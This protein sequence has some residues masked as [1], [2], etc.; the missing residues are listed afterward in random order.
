MLKHFPP[1]VF[2]LKGDAGVE[3]NYEG[4]AP[5][6]EALMPW[7][8]VKALQY[9]ASSFG[10]SLTVTLNEKGMLGAK[11]TKIKL[12][13]LGKQR[14]AFNDTAGHYWRRYQIM[15]SQQ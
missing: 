2:K 1:V 15:R 9:N 3:I 7:D 11:T 5:A 8:K 10:D 14:D 12:S 4:I 13:G 6:G